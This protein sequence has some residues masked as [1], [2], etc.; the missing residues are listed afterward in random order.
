MSVDVIEY[1]RKIREEHEAK[2]AAQSLRGK[3]RRLEKKKKK[4]KKPQPTRQ[5][6]QEKYKDEYK[7]L[8]KKAIQRANGKCELCG[9][10]TDNFV[11][12]HIEM[13]NEKPEKLLLYDNV[14]AICPLCHEEIHPWIRRKPVE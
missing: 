9:N 8:K 2:K 4:Q 6:L 10:E 12:H 14:L 5:E 3:K 1:W 11:L 13:V 7:E